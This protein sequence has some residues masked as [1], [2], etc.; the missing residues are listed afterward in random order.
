[1][2]ITIGGKSKTYKTR[3]G[4]EIARRVALARGQIVEARPV[5][6]MDNGGT[7]SKVE[8]WWPD[9]RYERREHVALSGRDIE[10]A[11]LAYVSAY[12][13]ERALKAGGARHGH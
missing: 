3:R 2:I 11:K 13:V 12:E 4:A 5:Y 6:A 7:Y 10:Y 8:T 1:M 9:G